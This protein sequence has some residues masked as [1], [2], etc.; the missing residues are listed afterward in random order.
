MIQRRKRVFVSFDYDND[1]VLKDFII[2]QARN[3][4]SPFEVTDW[5]MKE[6]APNSTWESEARA[7]ISRSDVVIVMV[8]KSTHR[9]PGVLKE[10]KMAEEAGKPIHPIIGYRDMTPTAVPGT[11]QLRRWSWET[12][13]KILST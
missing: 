4:D 10:V 5:S 2:G 3:P 9:A 7:R 8:G 12:L 6:A 11:G 13:K 1:K